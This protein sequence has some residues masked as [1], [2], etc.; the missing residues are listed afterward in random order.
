[1]ALALPGA[2]HCFSHMQDALRHRTKG[3]IA[4]R[5]GVHQALAD[6][7]WMAASVSSR[8]T[9]LAEIIPLLP[10]VLGDHDACKEGA[11]G[12]LFPAPTINMRRPH[13][14]HHTIFWRAPWPIDIQNE[15]VTSENPNGS[16]TMNDLELTGG[17]FQLEAAVQ[18]MDVRERTVLSRT[19]YSCSLFWQRK[20]SATSTRCTAHLLHLFGIHQR[21]HR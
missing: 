2:R 4:L 1:M 14:R 15:L 7:R 3:R 20:G 13:H 19:D 9:R 12:I 11:G 10:T 8:P 18:T 5:K 16:I 6:F 17:L 21:H